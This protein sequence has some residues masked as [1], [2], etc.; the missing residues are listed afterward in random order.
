MLRY[1][2]RRK[3]QREIHSKGEISS[4]RKKKP[5]MYSIQN[6]GETILRHIHLMVFLLSFFSKNVFLHEFHIMKV[7]NIVAIIRRP[8]PRSPT[9]VGCPPWTT[10]HER[11]HRG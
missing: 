7:S 5:I 4:S 10:R 11:C 3:G 8:F 9:D 1:Q 2:E 6:A